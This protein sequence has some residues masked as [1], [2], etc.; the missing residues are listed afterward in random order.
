MHTGYLFVLPRLLIYKAISLYSLGNKEKGEELYRI[1][2]YG[3]LL[4][5]MTDEVQEFKDYA[6]TEYGLVL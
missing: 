2:Y 1:G 3:F 6:Y 5:G 4:L